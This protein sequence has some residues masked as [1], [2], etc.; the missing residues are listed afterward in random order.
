MLQNHGLW[1]WDLHQMVHSQLTNSI[2][3]VTAGLKFNAM[4][5]RYPISKEPLLLHNP[6][7]LV[8]SRSHCFPIRMVIALDNK[9]PWMAFDRCITCF[10]LVKSQKLWTVKHL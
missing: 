10:V 6:D 9:K 4:V 3:H 7:P 8:Q 2:S 1:I 5:L